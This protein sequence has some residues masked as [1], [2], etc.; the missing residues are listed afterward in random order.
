V[1]Y[2]VAC[3][4]VASTTRAGD[5]VEIARR[6]PDGGG[7]E[8]RGTGVPEE[9]RFKGESILGKGKST[10]CS[11]FTFTV[12]MKAATRRGLLREKSVDEVRAFQKRWYGA[13]KESREQQ[14]VLA[15]ESL[16][17]GKQLAAEKAKSGDFLQFWRRDGSGHSVVFLGWIKEGRRRIGVKY[18]SSQPQT[19]GVGD[20]VE[21]FGDATS[22]NGLVAKRMYFCRLNGRDSRP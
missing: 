20:Y 22:S 12:A 19:K 1:V 8:W 4:L 7:Y 10:Y 3:C 21:Y 11:G 9:I 6:F 15:V 5:V 2:F 16:G 17:V 14:C 13:T 18:R